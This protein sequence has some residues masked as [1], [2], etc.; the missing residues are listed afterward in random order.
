[1]N[2]IAELVEGTVVGQGDVRITGLNGLKDAKSGDL[3]FLANPRFESL[4]ET[5]QATAVLVPENFGDNGLPVVR[6]GHPYLAFA[7]VLKIYEKEILLHPVG[8]HPSAAVSEGA[9]LGKNVGIDAF[10]RVEEGCELG[11]G[12]VL[13]S[14]V[15]VGRGSKIGKGSVVYPNVTIREAVTIGARCI[16]HSNVSLGSDG[17][18]FTLVDGAHVKIP[19]VGTVQIG[20]DVEIG[21]N[22]AIDRSTTGPTV[23]GNGT[24]I[25]NLVQIAHNVTIG[26]HC[27]ISGGTGIA[28]STKIGSNVVMGGQVGVRGHLEIGDNVIIGGGTGVTSSVPADSVIL[29]TPHYDHNVTRRIWV[30]LPRLPKMLRRLKVLEQRVDKMEE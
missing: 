15:Y 5:T 13:Y 2:E 9:S 22:S 12:V 30:S 25:D 7:T 8:I 11:D 28:G 6:V 1:M 24:K 4:M 27:T 17:F 21:S 18:G 23:I 19:Q 26:E 20:D 3:S 10:V 29:G 14:G 16:I